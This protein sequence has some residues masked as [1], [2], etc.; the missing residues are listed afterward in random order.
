MGISFLEFC[1]GKIM[2]QVLVIVAHPDDEVIGC[3]A[4]I[5]KWTSA[6]ISVHILIMA[7]GSTSRDSNAPEVNN[8]PALLAKSAQRAGKIIGASSVKL[9][10]FPDNRM[11]SL[12]RLVVIKEIEKAIKLLKPDTVVTHHAGDV[13]ID[14]RI[15]HESVVTACRPQPGNCV[16]RLL[17][18][19]VLSSTEWQPTGS[20]ASFQPN[21]FEDV[22]ENIDCKIKALKV[23][24]SEIRE[25]PHA[26]SLENVEHLARFRGATIGC[27]A[28]ESFILLR[29]IQ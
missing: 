8:S 10:G 23:Y 25:W 20:N 18:F 28:A 17:A 15:V 7:E 22:S 12:D 19:E 16:K 3:G 2:K 6:G 14:H 21:W 29:A 1:G 5:S 24:K 26:R 4:S 13:N 27:S 9:L 11:D